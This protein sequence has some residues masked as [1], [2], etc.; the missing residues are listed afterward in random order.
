MY[1]EIKKFRN[2]LKENFMS[3]IHRSREMDL[4]R[5]WIK[6][7]FDI[8]QLTIDI[9][10]DNSIEDIN[11]VITVKFNWTS[12]NSP[13]TPLFLWNCTFIVDFNNKQLSYGLILN[14]KIAINSTQ[15]EIKKHE[16]LVGKISVQNNNFLRHIED[17]KIKMLDKEMLLYDFGKKHY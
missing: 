9:K 7:I 14:Q 5:S 17:A 16:K 4:V 2:L 8:E 13:T 10:D 6:E 11:K 15:H 1:K 3:G 12:S